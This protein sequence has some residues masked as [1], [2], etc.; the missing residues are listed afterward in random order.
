MFLWRILANVIPTKEKLASILN[1][2]ELNYVICDS[3]INNTF[4][5][6]KECIR[7]RALAFESCWG[8]GGKEVG[9]LELHRHHVIYGDG[10][11]TFP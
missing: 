7:T 1:I 2:F 3:S 11:Q 8:R 9:C 4:H 10:A 5:L 6:F